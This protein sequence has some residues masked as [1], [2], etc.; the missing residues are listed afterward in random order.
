MSESLELKDLP[1]N[2]V[3][4]TQLEMFRRCPQQYQIRYIKGV[5]KPPAGNLVVGISAHKALEGDLGQKKVT[6][7]NESTDRVKER[8]SSAFDEVVEEAKTGFG[9]V[10][11]EDEDPGK[12]KDSMLGALSA[13]HKTLAQT[14]VPTAVEQ[15]FELSFDKASFTLVGRLDAVHENVEVID[16]KTTKKYRKSIENEVGHPMPFQLGVYQLAKPDAEILRLDYMIRGK[17]EPDSCTVAYPALTEEGVTDVLTEI[18]TLSTAIRTGLFYPNP[19]FGMLNCSMCGYKDLCPAWRRRVTSLP[20]DTSGS[21]PGS[22]GSELVSPTHVAEPSIGR[23]SGQS[24]SQAGDS[25]I[26]RAPTSQSSS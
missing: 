16:F 23:P 6:G 20:R 15:A 4:V 13:Y 19:G 17:K 7:V 21:T 12:E 14:I 9:G 18:H 24:R 26:G 5:K 22:P 3:S 1:H 8:A 25:E 11:W 2:Y 10:N